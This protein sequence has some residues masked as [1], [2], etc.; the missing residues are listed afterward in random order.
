MRSLSVLLTACGTAVSPDIRRVITIPASLSPPRPVPAPK[1]AVT[2]SLG[3]REESKPDLVE[4]I[5]NMRVLLLHIDLSS[6]RAEQN[7]RAHAGRF[8]GVNI[9]E[10]VASKDA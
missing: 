7:H 6:S 2:V 9:R 3:G 1:L 8:S 10:L 5:G 4:R